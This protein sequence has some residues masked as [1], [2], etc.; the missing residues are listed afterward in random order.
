MGA[1]P[2]V[3]PSSARERE[4]G[5]HRS[6]YINRH[7]ALQYRGE[8]KPSQAEVVK[9]AAPHPRSEASASRVV[10]MYVAPAPGLVGNYVG[11]H[12]Q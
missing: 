8:A 5:R 3:E 2:A 4:R 7:W 9:G 12:R 11:I 1:H 10:Y 6:V